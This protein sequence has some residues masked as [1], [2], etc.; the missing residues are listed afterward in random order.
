MQ[1]KAAWNEERSAIF[2]N[3]RFRVIDV[4]KGEQEGEFISL[5]YA[6]GIVGDQ[7]MRVSSMVY[8][9]PGERGIYFIESKTQQLIN[10]M[11]GWGQGHFV[12]ALDSSGTE[13]VLTE[14][15]KKVLSLSAP[16]LPQAA[17]ASARSRPAGEPSEFSHGVARGIVTEEDGSA[18]TTAMD[19]KRFKQALRERLGVRNGEAQR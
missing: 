6:G 9:Q 8:P 4:I 15:R 12:L 1:S 10:P 14:G 3:I 13:R 18:V 17:N 11:V 16:E 2:T 5:K 7:D 19:K